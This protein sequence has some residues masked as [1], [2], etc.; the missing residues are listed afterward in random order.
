MAK[1]KCIMDQFME[2]LKV[3]GLLDKIK[4][5]PSVWEPLFIYSSALRLTEGSISVVH[6]IIM[7]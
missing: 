7:L 5:Q 3:L 4:Q 6:I 2:G 1:V